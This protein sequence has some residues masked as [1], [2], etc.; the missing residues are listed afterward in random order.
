MDYATQLSQVQNTY[1]EALSTFSS[2]QSD[3][4]GAA[5]GLEKRGEEVEGITLPVAGISPQCW[6]TW[7]TRAWPIRSTP[8]RSSRRRLR[9][10]HRN[11]W[12]R[13]QNWWN[14]SRLRQQ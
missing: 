14:R 2:K 1:D 13:S 5:Q 12:I 3:I 4:I 11:G 9:E 8:R 7:S 6:R 10:L